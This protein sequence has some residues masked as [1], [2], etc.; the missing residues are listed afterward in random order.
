MGWMGLDLSVDD[1]HVDEGHSLTEEEAVNALGELFLHPN[2]TI[3]LFGCFRSIAQKIVEKA[4]SLLRLVPDLRLYS[5]SEDEIFR[6]IGDLE[7]VVE[8]VDFYFRS[9]R[10]LVLHELALPSLQV[11]I[12]FQV[13]GVSEVEVGERKDRV[14]DALNATRAAVEEGIVPGKFIFPAS[15]VKFILFSMTGITKQLFL[16][17]GGIALLYATKVL[18][19]LQTENEDQ[20]RGI[21]IIENA[22]KAPTLTIVSNAGG[23]GPLVVG[24]LLEQNDV[25][26]GYDAARGKYVNMVKVGIVDPL[27]VIRTA[28]VDAAS[29]S[30]L[31]TT[32]EATVVDLQGEKN[33][34]AN[35]MPN[36]DDMGY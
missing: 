6:G 9:G 28:L 3:P 12:F 32:T 36:M 18:E 25:S 5:D 24:K 16:I 29:V 2:Y 26:L 7:N 10:T 15:K 20:K 23:D 33:P 21:Q 19:N 1:N 13:G 4:V 31:L 8:V 11:F 14:T 27:K 22:L 30:I 17:G 35:R 34:L